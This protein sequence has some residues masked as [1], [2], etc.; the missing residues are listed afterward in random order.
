[1]T[2]PSFSHCEL[3]VSNPRAP[4]DGMISSALLRLLFLD[5][6]AKVP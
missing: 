4:G 3:L 5:S 6:K 1:M 2:C